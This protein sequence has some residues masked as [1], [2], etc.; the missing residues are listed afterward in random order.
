VTHSRS[1]ARFALGLFAS[2]LLASGALAA[3]G[4][5][6]AETGTGQGKVVAVDAAAGEVTID[7]G[8]IPGM[9]GAM[10]MSFVVSDPKLL[11]GIAAGQQVEFTLQHAAG[12]YTV[13]A[14]RPVG[15]P[16]R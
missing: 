7:H 14:I 13:T 1:A 12:K 15:G 2:L 4:G 11:D 6:S 5:G 8:E 16:A 3:C 10:T 9:M